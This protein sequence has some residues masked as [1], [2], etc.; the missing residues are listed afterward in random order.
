MALPFCIG[1]HK[2]AMGWFPVDLGLVV[3][4]K[5]KFHA[6]TCIRTNCL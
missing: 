4:D 3:V 5:L 2:Q 1:M 6:S